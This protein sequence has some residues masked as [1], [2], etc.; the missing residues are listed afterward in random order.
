MNLTNEKLEKAVADLV[1][2]KNLMV[3]ELTKEQVA[4]AKVCLLWRGC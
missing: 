1:E 4:M 2:Q 3:E